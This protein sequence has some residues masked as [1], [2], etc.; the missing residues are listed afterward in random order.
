MKFPNDAAGH[1]AAQ[2]EIGQQPFRMEPQF[3]PMEAELLA[4]HKK[5]QVGVTDKFR[6]KV[7]TLMLPMVAVPAARLQIQ[8]DDLQGIGTL[9]TSREPVA[10]EV[11]RKIH[12]PT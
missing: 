2:P 1:E 3:L 8:G 9:A 10:S 5:N 11:S 7:E 4:F 12:G 6:Q